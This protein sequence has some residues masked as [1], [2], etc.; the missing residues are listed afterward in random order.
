MTYL[1]LRGIQTSIH[2]PPVH[3]FSFHRQ[4][5]KTQ[6]MHLTEHIAGH[7]LTLPMYAGITNEQVDYIVDALSNYFH[8]T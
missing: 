1:R 4:Y 8:E 7:E 3:E 2:Y 6:N 5:F